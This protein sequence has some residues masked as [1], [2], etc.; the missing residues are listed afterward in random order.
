MVDFQ[1]NSKRA[2]SRSKIQPS[3]SFY[4]SPITTISENAT[5]SSS[6]QPA[7][8]YVKLLPLPVLPNAPVRQDERQH[9]LKLLHH[10][11]CHCNAKFDQNTQ[12]RDENVRRNL[13]KKSV[14]KE[15]D[16]AQSTKTKN[17]YQHTIKKLMFNLKKFGTEDG[18]PKPINDSVSTDLFPS[19]GSEFEF[20]LVY[21]ELQALCISKNRL[22]KNGFVIE[23]PEIPNDYKLPEKLECLRCETLFHIK[24]IEKK[25]DC[26]YHPGKVQSS[27]YE[28]LSMGRKVYGTDYLNKFY[29]CCN[30][31]K[32]Q[33]AGCQTHDHHVYK[34]ND[35]KDLHL[36]KNFVHITDLRNSLNI[37]NDTEIQKMRKEKIK[38]VSLDCEMCFTNNGFEMMK[39]SLIDFKTEK[40][41]IDSIVHPDGDFIIDL[42]SHVSGVDDIPK[43][44]MTF[45]EV[46]IKIAQLCDEDTIIVGHGLENDL[47]V[48][49]LI[50]PKIVDTAILY[51]ENQINS[52]RKDPLKKLAWKY[53]SENIQGKEHDSL[54]DAIIPARI[55][56][57]QIDKS[58]RIKER[59]RL[60]R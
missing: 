27:I 32:G 14:L 43:D 20:G 33:S 17:E 41:L 24:D 8:D 59:N 58:L 38:A 47:N 57:K 7:I 40:K 34:Y 52:R 9:Y 19:I 49:R 48:L 56:K 35:I 18:L 2:T 55:V 29:V 44:A 28:N 3:I 42:N 16:I 53:L 31:P 30:E 10:Q 51:S 46:M 25:V 6:N 12:M 5:T 50:F 11:Y 37:N 21:K 45:D 39:L 54:E 26:T 60:R 22:K 4:H 1:N 36:M 23:V 15:F 13:I